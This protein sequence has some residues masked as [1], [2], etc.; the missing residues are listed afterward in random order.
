MSYRDKPLDIEGMPPGIPNI[1]GNEG[2]ERFSFYGMK[3]ILVVFMTKHLLDS[4]G[5]LD[6]MSEA[7]AMSWFHLFTAAL[8]GLGFLGAILSDG[9][10][11]KYRTI[12]YLSIVYCLGH[13]ALAMDETRLGLAV[14]LSLIALGSGGIKPCVSAH[15]GD[16]FG[17]SNSH[18]REKVFAWFYLAINAG[19]M[20]SMLLTPWLLEHHGPSWAFGVPG[21]AMGI[22]TMVFW[23]GR[24]RFAH[25]PPGGMAFLK[26][27]FG[28]REGWATLGKV[29]LI[30]AFVAVFWALYDQTGS[31]WVLQAGKMDLNFLGIKWLPSQVQAVNP[32][33]ILVLSPLFAYVIYPMMSRLFDP[34]P[35]RKMGIGFALCALSFV[36]TA[37]I[38][39][40]IV[41]G[42]TPSIGWQILGYLVITAAEVMVSITCLDFAYSQ[43]LPTMK[44]LVMAIFL[45]SVSLG[46]LFT[47][48]VNVFIQNADGTTK[49]EGSSYYLF[50]AGVMVVTMFVFIPVA[51]WYPEK[52][53]PVANKG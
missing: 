17:K 29:S 38:E 34:K 31:A 48:G 19:A 20:I 24:H 43:A 30:F 37:W 50:F 7:D 42:N 13:L 26:E 5:A 39:S 4:T 21:I 14:G 41:A 52:E 23:M 12:M 8:Y 2:A 47:S 53:P 16:Q 9:F 35:L 51:R 27:T 1:V 15:V 36:L 28:S 11:G 44:S 22:A 45:F 6:P 25:I 46:N 18:L 40:Q 3:G 32:V 10:L 33:L 49:L